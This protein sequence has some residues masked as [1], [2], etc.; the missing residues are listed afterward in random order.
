MSTYCLSFFF[1]IRITREDRANFSNNSQRH[2][3]SFTDGLYDNLSAGHVDGQPLIKPSRSRLSMEQLGSKS[4]SGTLPEQLNLQQQVPQSAQPPYKTPRQMYSRLPPLRGHESNI[5]A[6]PSMD[7]PNGDLFTESPS[8][9]YRQKPER[10]VA[11][12]VPDGKFIYPL[13]DNLVTE[14]VNLSV[15]P[16]SLSEMLESVLGDSLLQSI[17]H[18]MPPEL[19]NP[20]LVHPTGGTDITPGNVRPSASCP[21][22]TDLESSPPYPMGVGNSETYRRFSATGSVDV[23]EEEGHPL[24]KPRSKPSGP[25]RS[26]TIPSSCTDPLCHQKGPTNKS[27]NRHPFSNYLETSLDEPPSAPILDYSKWLILT[28]TDQHQRQSQQQHDK[29]HH[30]LEQLQQQP[31]RPLPNQWSDQPEKKQAI[32]NLEKNFNMSDYFTKRTNFYI[33]DDNES[34]VT[35]SSQESSSCDVNTSTEPLLG[36]AA[37]HYSKEKLQQVEANQETPKQTR[38]FTRQSRVFSSKVTA[39]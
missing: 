33:G 1:K 11:N 22:V 28:K 13:P 21:S 7:N 35:M 17:G 24:Q 39:V 4:L 23:P 36:S 12:N 9:G 8:L 18:N 25:R 2:S 29:R 34:P 26:N 10:K 32:L 20:I 14:S 37:P 15:R 6:A 16:H 19:G 27:S 3:K 5:G 38:V 31:G 30:P